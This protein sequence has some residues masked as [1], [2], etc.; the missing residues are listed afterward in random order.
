[1]APNPKV[2]EATKLMALKVRAYILLKHIYAY[3]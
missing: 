3:N 2:V 1:M